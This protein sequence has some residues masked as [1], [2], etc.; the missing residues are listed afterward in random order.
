LRT[1]P[2]LQGAWG[3][4]MGQ[5]RG[6]GERLVNRLRAVQAAARRRPAQE[7]ASAEKGRKG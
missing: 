7:A 2:Q 1:C 5:Q 6:K 4:G 3:N